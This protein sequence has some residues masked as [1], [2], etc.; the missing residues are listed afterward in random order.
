MNKH[1]ILCVLISLQFRVLETAPV[2]LIPGLGGSGLQ[3]SVSNTTLSSCGS[4]ILN[5]TERVWLSFS[6]W[7]PPRSHQQCWVQLMKLNYTLPS[8]LAFRCNDWK[9][10]AGNYVSPEGIV[11]SSY[12]GIAA[13]EYLDYI[14]GYGIPLARYFHDIIEALRS[15]PGSVTL[16]AFPYDWRLPVWQYPWQELKSNIES[17]VSLE[18]KRAVLIVHSLGGIAFNWFLHTQVDHDWRQKHIGALI[19]IN[20][21]FGGSF[22]IVRALMSGYNPAEMFVLSRWG[23]PQLISNRDLREVSRTLGS[24]FLL[25]PDEPVHHSDT[26]I[27]SVLDSQHNYST[28]N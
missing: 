21:A 5:F 27:I 26:P 3:A 2:F 10:R 17:Q 14:E 4:G 22:K 11:V 16:H 7:R 13:V 28:S 25:T 8:A 20:G 24:L 1:Y 9:C 15:V 12:S 18:K 6:A 19:S 23:L